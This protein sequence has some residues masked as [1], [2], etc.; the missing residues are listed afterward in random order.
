MTWLSLFLPVLASAMLWNLASS[1]HVSRCSPRLKLNSVLGRCISLSYVEGPT[2]PP[3]V[4]STLGDY[5]SQNVLNKYPHQPALI[6]RE[7]LPGSSGGPLGRN[8]GLS[9]HLAWD[10]EEFDVNIAAA[11][12]GL[13][14]MGVKK[15]D[16]VGAIIPNLR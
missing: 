6:C 13:L 7:E 10:Y 2:Q 16:R 1:R 8:L 3:L 11:T 9:S 12:R 15:G 5:F 4:T 14:R